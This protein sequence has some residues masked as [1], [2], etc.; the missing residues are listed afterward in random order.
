MLTV[1][2][3]LL[4]PP[5]FESFWSLLCLISFAFSSDTWGRNQLLAFYGNMHQEFLS[6][7]ARVIVRLPYCPSLW[8]RLLYPSRCG[9]NHRRSSADLRQQ[10]LLLSAPPPPTSTSPQVP[11]ILSH[12]SVSCLRRSCRRASSVAVASSSTLRV[13]LEPSLQ[14]LLRHETDR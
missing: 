14:D 4:R 11:T 6:N 12:L 8:P 3:L 9:S 5:H 10:L 13:V 7:L 1:L 2:D